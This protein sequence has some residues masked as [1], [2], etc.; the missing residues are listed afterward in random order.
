[1]KKIT[2]ARMFL[3]LIV[4]GAMGGLSA[5]TIPTQWSTNFIG[6]LAYAQTHHAPL[7]VI[8]GN[9]SCPNCEK[10]HKTLTDI[11]LKAWLAEHP[12]VTV[13]KHDP[14]DENKYRD[15]NSWKKSWSDDYHAAWDWIVEKSG[16]GEKDWDYPVVGLYWKL[17]DGNEKVKRFFVGRNSLMPQK[18]DK[19]HTT[20]AD[21]LRGSLDKYFA[22]YKAG[23]EFLVGGTPCDRLEA[24]AGT[25]QAVVPLRRTLLT[26][27]FVSRLTVT[28]PNGVTNS[29]DYAWEGVNERAYLSVD[30]PSGVFAEG[31][32]IELSLT[33]D[34]DEIVRTSSITFVGEDEP[35]PKNPLWIG[36]RT[37]DT[38]EAGEWTMD[39]D[40]VK[41]RANAKGSPALILIGGSLW[42]PD[43]VKTDHYLVDTK[44]FKDWLVSN[45]VSCAAIDVPKIPL[46]G[47]TSLLT[48]DASTASE[49]YVLATTPNQESIQ[50]GAG[51]LSRHSVSMEDALSIA[52]RNAALVTNAVPLGLC[53]PEQMSGDNSETGIFNTGIPCLVM[54]RPDGTIAGRLYQFNNVSP[55]NTNSVPAYISRMDE[56]VRLVAESGEELNADWRSTSSTIEPNGT[57]TSTISAIDL[58]DAYRLTSVSNWMRGAIRVQSDDAPILPIY[59]TEKNVRVTLLK[60]RNNEIESRQVAEGNLFSGVDLAVVCDD[61][62]ADWFVEI[63]ALDSAKTFLLEREDIS[64]TSYSMTVSLE[65]PP[66]TIAFASN[67]RSVS[68]KTAGRLA[69][70]LVRGNGAAG[71]VTARITLDSELTTATEET[72]AWTDTEVSWTDGEEG[73]EKYVYLD[74][75]N[76]SVWDGPR[77]IALR[78]SEVTGSHN[79]E[80]SETNN[81]YV[82]AVI[83]DDKR[84]IGK[85]AITQTDPALVKKDVV[86]VRENSVL[87]IG[88]TRENGASGAV[89]TSLK[90]DAGV[91][92][93]NKLIWAHSDRVA[94]KEVNLMVPTLAD[95]GGKKSFKVALVSPE[96]ITIDKARKTLTVEVVA[97]DATGFETDAI[98]YKLRRYVAFEERFE[99]GYWQGGQL[100]LTK[101]SGSLPSGVSA[102]LERNGTLIELVLSGTPSKVQSCTA[103]YQVSEK[104]PGAN[105]TKVVTTPG[106]TVRILFNVL[107]V[108]AAGSDG[109]PALNPS[110]ATSRTF[111]DQRI[112]DDLNHRMVGLLTFTVP[113]TGKVS[114]KYRGHKGTVSFSAKRWDVC[115]ESTGMLTASLVSTKG[116]SLTIRAKSD[117][118]LDYD[119]V[120]TNESVALVDQCAFRTYWGSSNKATA[121]KG[122]YSVDCPMTSIVSGVETNVPAGDAW[123]TMNISSSTALKKG[124][125]TYAGR[126]PNGVSFSG[127]GTLVKSEIDTAFLP[128]MM[129]TSSDYFTAVAE[130]NSDAETSYMSMDE[131][132]VM[133]AAEE[134]DPYW[135]HVSSVSALPEESYEVS[136]SLYGGYYRSDENLEACARVENRFASLPLWFISGGMIDEVSCSV[137]ETKVRVTPNAVNPA[138]LTMTFNRTTGVVSGSFKGAS[139]AGILMPGWG[140]CGACSP[141]EVHLPLVAGSYWCTVNVPYAT[142]SGKVKTASV[143]RGGFAGIGESEVET[144]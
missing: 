89:A 40:L 76:D 105:P 46:G 37:L 56:L 101:R 140:G 80:A 49:R 77:D 90:T 141:G 137:T 117:G 17:P 108:T 31:E 45:D 55:A 85:L 95:L 50:S 67:G 83:E 14:W 64:T 43:C 94:T 138:K 107:S 74:V 3:S 143:K 61:T 54:M 8:W 22:S 2:L 20:L 11:K 82:V 91:L 41:A 27:N 122:R 118:T 109:S 75:I 33:S 21:Q 66:S 131:H 126:L 9:Q 38:L 116:Y 26:T 71:T 97:A 103:V 13:S 1:M 60:I 88:V 106:T 73:K 84:E 52:E 18:P 44:P 121:W 72:Y 115:D 102:R 98:S 34:Q 120:D 15:F 96:S 42:C 113:V 51:Y 53:R 62:T 39:Y 127:S 99:V 30:I 142:A 128:V 93:S 59:A 29:I 132:R 7:V 24:R 78:I 79:P 134:A 112:V 119:F 10:L 86:V 6:S 68:E 92:S 144:E 28:F 110:I 5:D 87:A 25:R 136:F 69:I 133:L 100:V 139:W 129:R 114:A 123:M 57:L 23:A 32:V 104:R 4:M 124:T 81:V 70:P 135:C 63:R 36:E 19:T 16:K 111:A 35:T 58:V 12:I 65:S 48:Y 47:T 125:V 130:I